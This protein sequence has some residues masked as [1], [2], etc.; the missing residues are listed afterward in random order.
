MAK[1]QLENGHTQIA[2]ELLEQLAKLYLPPNQWQVLLFIIRKTYGFRKKVDYIASPQIIAGTGLG[3]QV[4]SRALIKLQDRNIIIRQKKNIGIQKDWERWKSAELLTIGT[5]SA[6]QLTSAKVSRTANQ[7]KLNSLP[8]S[9]EQLTKV[10]SPDDTQKKETI[11][12]K[13]YK[14]KGQE[15]MF[16]IFWEAYPKKAS[17]G[18][19]EKA[20]YSIAPDDKLLELMLESIKLAKQ[21]EAWLKEGGRYIKNPATWLNAKCWE[22]EIQKGGDHGEARGYS[23]GSTRRIPQAGE[24]TDPRAIRHSE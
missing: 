13:L 14:R 20:F 10:S 8:E 16:L 19:A 2:N 24:Y 17:K 12:K 22:D 1:P 9:A 21:S 15:K 5:K 6:E 4:I 7:S 11:Q 23:K 3:K 18:Q